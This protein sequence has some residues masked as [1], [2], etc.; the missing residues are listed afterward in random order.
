MVEFIAVP[1][2]GCFVFVLFDHHKPVCTGQACSHEPTAHF[3]S[4]CM[5]QVVGGM[6]WS[7]TSIGAAVDVD[8][9]YNENLNLGQKM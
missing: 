7:L 5:P 9:F 1:N 8:V 2:H 6:C 4:L 3:L